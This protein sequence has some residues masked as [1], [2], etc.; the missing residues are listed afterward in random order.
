MAQDRDALNRARKAK[1]QRLRPVKAPKTTHAEK[2]PKQPKPG[3][4]PTQH[5]DADENERTTAL[6]KRRVFSPPP[7][8]N[9]TLAA[10]VAA[11]EARLRAPGGMEAFASVIRRYSKRPEVAALFPDETLAGLVLASVKGGSLPG[12]MGN[13]DRVGIWR[14]I[15]APWGSH[16]T[17]AGKMSDGEIDG[18]ATSTAEKVAQAIDRARLRGGAGR[19]A[20]PQVTLDG[21]ISSED[22]TPASGFDAG[23]GG[24]S[25]RVEAMRI[26]RDALQPKVPVL[27][28]D[29]PNEGNSDEVAVSWH[30]R[31]SSN[32]T[33]V[34]HSRPD[35]AALRRQMAGAGPDAYRSPAGDLSWLDGGDQGEAEPEDRG[36]RRR[37]RPAPKRSSGG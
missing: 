18:I 21:V 22:E 2:T 10:G 37:M 31:P 4:Q 1:T 36:E 33:T 27:I 15:N 8:K 9:K 34:A 5:H 29:G 11:F 35:P 14:M 26:A 6:S 16:L 32:A 30:G 20:R 3:T 23:S 24:Y 25:S 12:S 7:S 13:A 17:A 19:V 28:D